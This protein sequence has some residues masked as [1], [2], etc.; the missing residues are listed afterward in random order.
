MAIEM[1][2]QNRRRIADHERM[3]ELAGRS[4]FISFEV[5][6]QSPNMPPEKYAVTYTCKGIARI[7]SR[8][9][10]E[11][12]ELHQV[13]IYL[14]ADY[15]SNQPAMRWLTPIWHPN[16]EHE[17]PFRVCV[18][19]SWWTAN[20]TLDQLCLMLGEMIQYKNYHATNEKPYPF[21]GEAADWVRTW[22][23][24]NGIVS[25]KKPVDSRELLRPQRVTVKAGGLTSP[26]TSTRVKVVG[27]SR[28][29]STTRPRI[30]LS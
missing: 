9:E 26:P 11:Y 1:T 30:K 24:P 3:V 25:K 29:T 7:N 4:D 5:L 27:T 10:P 2:P 23:E 17:E 8:Q 19:A 14:H 16:I 12:S 28:S 21:D 18:D 15:P 13:A 22:A 6:E 20:R